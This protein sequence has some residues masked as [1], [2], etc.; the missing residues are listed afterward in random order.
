[1]QEVYCEESA[2]T[3]GEGGEGR[4]EMRRL[5]GGGGVRPETRDI[6]LTPPSRTTRQT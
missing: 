6:S 1:M 5:V 2:E 3:G 4:A